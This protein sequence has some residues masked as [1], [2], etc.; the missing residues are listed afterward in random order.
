VDELRRKAFSN[1]KIKTS[2]MHRMYKYRLYP[3]KQQETQ[4]TRH[5][6]ICKD[7][8]N[9]LL[10]HCRHSPT[11]PSQYTLNKLLPTLKQDNPEYADVH[12]QV[13]QNISKRIRDAYHGYHA[14][15][16]AGLKAGRPRYKS[17]DRYKSM[18]YPQSGFKVEGDRLT[19]SKIGSMRIRLHRPIGGD[20]KTLTVKRMPSGRW[21]AVFCCEVE[22]QPMEISFEEVGVD[23]GLECFATLSDG[24]RIENPR[25]YRAS[26]RRLTR[27]Q[28]S[29]SRKEKGS[30][31]RMRARLRVARL[32]EKI[33]NRR[34][35]FLHKASRAVT[36]SYGT[37]YVEDLK[38]RNMVRNHCLAKSIQ[39][40]G[41]GRFVRML[42]YKEEESGGRVVLVNPCGTSQR[43]SGCGEAVVKSLSVRVHECPYCGLVLDRDLN[44]ARNIL[45]IG[46]GP[47]DLKPVER[48]TSVRP[49][50]AGQV[51]SVKQEAALLVGK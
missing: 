4:L 3:R 43:C 25:Y 33:E 30:R 28:R 9:T 47:P 12:S 7:I 2:T 22:A 23:L 49:S 8:H 27:L 35:D 15:R 16:K 26:E 5:L 20:V 24:T 10:H 41:W 21:Y 48:L 13:L 34:S 32:H 29:L 45:E 44:A 14:R 36:N 11:P 37:V 42:C 31:N 38:I 40:A 51:G 39:D 19:L 18:T 50:G 1:S 46:R 17:T 6:N